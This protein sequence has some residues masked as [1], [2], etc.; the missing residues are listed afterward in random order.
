MRHILSLVQ[1]S[2]T[3]LISRISENVFRVF[4]GKSGKAYF[5]TVNANGSTKCTC[6]WAKFR[7]AND[8]RSVCSHTIAV[9][10]TIASED[11]YN[12]TVRNGSPARFEHLHRKT[13]KTG[14]GATATLRLPN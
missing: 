1:K 13:I 2:N 12:L 11:G 3:H 7:P 5:V 8:N 4:S 14:D 9:M 10:N 6:D